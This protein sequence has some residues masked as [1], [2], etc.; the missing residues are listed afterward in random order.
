[1]G[2]NNVIEIAFTTPA[3]ATPQKRVHLIYDYSSEGTGNFSIIEGVTGLA[4]GGGTAFTPINKQ[5]ASTNVSVVT[6][7]FTG[8]TGAAITYAGGTTIWLRS[9]GGNRSSLSEDRAT[10]EIILAPATSYVFKLTNTSGGTQV[11][12]LSLTW[13]EHTDD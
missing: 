8:Q 3:V 11:G 5:R 9:W 4:I 2:N 1:M 10:H 7:S 12:F 6:N 13:Y